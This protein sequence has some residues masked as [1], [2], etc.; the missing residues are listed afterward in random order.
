MFLSEFSRDT[1]PADHELIAE[2]I[3]LPLEQPGLA[4]TRLLALLEKS[5]RSCTSTIISGRAGTGK[6]TLALDFA[7]NCGRLVSWYKVDAP[8]AD[9]RSFFPVVA[10]LR[11]RQAAPMVGSPLAITGPTEERPCP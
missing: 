6:T 11:L 3:A 1:I 9:P 7:H 8:D 5:L 2:K 10:R 4:R